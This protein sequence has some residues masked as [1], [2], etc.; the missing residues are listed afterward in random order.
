MVL[1]NNLKNHMR[2]FFI[3]YLLAQ[4]FNYSLELMVLKFGEKYKEPLKKK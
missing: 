2:K 4:N 3:G 1:N